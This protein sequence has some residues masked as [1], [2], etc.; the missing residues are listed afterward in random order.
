MANGQSLLGTMF[1]TPAEVERQRQQR[2]FEQARQSAALTPEQ[3][4]AFIAARS[5]QMTGRLLSDVAGFEDPELKKARELQGIVN[6]VKNS[7]SAADQQDPAKV[8]SALAKRAGELG[9]TRE[10]MMLAD[11]ATRRS[12][13]SEE[14]GMRKQEFDL[15][16]QKI[17]QGE[18]TNMITK[19][20]DAVIQKGGQLYVQKVDDE[21]KVSLEPYKKSTHGAFETKSEYSGAGAGGGVI[22]KP[23]YNPGGIVIGYDILDKN[24]TFLRRELFKDRGGKG[25]AASTAPAP[26]T[27]P[28]KK[29]RPSIGSALFPSRGQ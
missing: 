9:Y 3:Q 4:G 21:G 28:S 7:L 14:F 23:V 12:R 5:G 11:E 25:E 17:E 1:Q 15:K 10:S 20:G 13:E 27:A 24:G 22:T 18:L 6:E 8:Y 19:K 2:L 16:K 26:T 29:E